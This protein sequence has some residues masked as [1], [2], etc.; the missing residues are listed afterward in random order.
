M[1]G[2]NAELTCHIDPIASGAHHHVQ[3]LRS[4]STISRNDRVTRY[5]VRNRFFISTKKPYNLG[6]RNADLYDA[7]KY[8]CND[9]LKGVAIGDLE[10][11]LV[12][13]NPASCPMSGTTTFIQNDTITFEWS[14]TYA[15]ERDDSQKPIITWT[16][17]GIEQTAIAD[18]TTLGV[19]K[20]TFTKTASSYDNQKQ[21]NCSFSV[22]NI[23]QHCSTKLKIIESLGQSDIVLIGGPRDRAVLS[24]KNAELT[25]HIDRIASGARHLVQWIGNS[26]RSGLSKPLSVN[27]TV[28]AIDI[29]NKFYISTEKPYNLGLRNIDLDDAGKYTCSD[30]LRGKS[31]GGLEPH[32]VVLDPASCPMSG[33]TIFYQNDIITFEW[34]VTYAGERDDSQKPTITWTL[35]G[36]KLTSPADETTP[37]VFKSTFTQKAYSYHNQKQLNCSFSVLNIQQHCSTKLDVRRNP[38]LKP[39]L[40]V[41]GKIIQD[42]AILQ[43]K[44]GTNVQLKGELLAKPMPLYT[45]WFKSK[46]HQDFD[47]VD[48]RDTKELN[49]IQFNQTGI[50]RCCVSNFYFEEC[51]EV[52]IEVV[53][54]N[55][56]A[57]LKR[58]TT[59][60][61]RAIMF[62]CAGG[63]STALFIGFNCA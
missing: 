44:V 8:T 19:F 6:L 41:N 57:D 15:G 60:Q 58:A 4:G 53:G 55:T 10:P 39:T 30:I 61:R 28:I 42:Q 24:G 50:Y 48:Y 1:S 17:N 7:G 37:G 20:S 2:Q 9:A 31:I 51:S 11:H 16:L 27:D 21:L 12:V 59:S 3:W 36:I 25:C 54:P 63:S 45:W 26:I 47:T 32:L 62:I 49:D 38:A 14:V 29:P 35:D 52:T 33:T 46:C 56:V 23:Q 22:L 34:S 18:E 5:G 13:L 40:F 43:R